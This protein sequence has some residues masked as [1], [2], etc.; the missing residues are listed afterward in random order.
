M[1]SSWFL[2]RQH[3]PP[4]GEIKLT[5]MSGVVRGLP[6]QSYGRVIRLIVLMHAC[7]HISAAYF[8]PFMLQELQLSY[9]QFT[10]LNAATLVTRVVASWYW[11]EIARNFGNRRALQVSAV[12]L[13]P[14]AGLWVL[15]RD[16]TYLLALQ[17]F[18]GFAWAGFEL[19]TILSF[20]DTT[21]ERTRALVLSLFNLLNGVAIVSA[22]LIGGLVLRQFGSDGYMYIFLAS[23][24]LR[25]FVVLL[26]NS[27][28]GIRR[29]HE[30][31]F[32][33]VFMR[34]ISFRP[35][36]GADL[37]PV[38]MDEPTSNSRSGATSH[39]PTS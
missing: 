26:F 18:A 22:S 19:T 3:E 15:S 36:Q 39:P 37:R 16:F 35:G 14:L 27:G 32:Q 7:V 38:V 31:T 8:T 21:D 10:V 11:G 1:V 34:V 28:A 5:P 23:S 9:A 20:F 13:V 25:L 2:T 29:P 6:Q 33:N 17:L 4:A 12:M 30:H 24:I